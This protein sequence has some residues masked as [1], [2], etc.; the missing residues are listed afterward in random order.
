[1]VTKPKNIELLPTGLLYSKRAERNF[2]TNLGQGA[3]LPSVLQQ[4][5]SVNLSKKIPKLLRILLK[6]I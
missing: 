3:K 5:L 2:M 4:K 1:M 6:L